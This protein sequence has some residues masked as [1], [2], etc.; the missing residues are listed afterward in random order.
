MDASVRQMP[1]DNF[2][3]TFKGEESIYFHDHPLENYSNLVLML[4]SLTFFLLI[5]IFDMI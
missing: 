1:F 2:T 4:V 3:W 5:L